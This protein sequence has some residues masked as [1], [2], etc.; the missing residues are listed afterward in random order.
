MFQTNCTCWVYVIG[1]DA[2]GY[3]ARIFPDSDGSLTNPVAPGAN[4]L[5]P[6]GDQWWAL[7]DQ[8][9]I[10]QIYFVA[11]RE[12]RPDIEAAID[13]LA[14]QPRRLNAAGL[15]PVMEPAVVPATRGLVKVEA[16][17]PV[18]LPLAGR[19]PARVHHLHEYRSG[20]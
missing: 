20:H 14:S 1:V 3:V 18:T 6:G 9:G 2:T 11:S 17:A 4:H 13:R 7:D 12:Q 19:A 5:M 8:R 10:E 16:P 15:Q